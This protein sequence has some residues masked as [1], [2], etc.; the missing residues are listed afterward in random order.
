[1]KEHFRNFSSIFSMM[2][3]FPVTGVKLCLLSC[4]HFVE[5]CRLRYAIMNFPDKY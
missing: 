3:Y 5:E 2:Q 4:T 1:M